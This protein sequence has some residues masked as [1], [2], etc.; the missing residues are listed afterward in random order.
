MNITN[1]Q[2]RLLDEH[3]SPAQFASG[4]YDACPSFISMDEAREAITKY[5]L[6][7]E[8]AGIAV[9]KPNRLAIMPKNEH[10]VALGK[11]GG[12]RKSNAKTN[13]ARANGKLGGRPSKKNS[14]RKTI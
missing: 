2:K 9:D 13:A 6:E 7:W 4:C 11:I 10:A 5:N 12:S 8:R 14:H 1:A 3:G